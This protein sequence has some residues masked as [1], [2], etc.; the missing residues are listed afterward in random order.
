MKFSRREFGRE[1]LGLVDGDDDRLAPDAQS[2]GNVVIRRGQSFAA[3]DHE[4]HRVGLVHGCQRLAGG[5]RGQFALVVG[6]SAGVD[7]DH[8]APTGVGEAIA[9]IPG[10]ARVVR[11]QRVPGTGELV[12]QRG[13]ANV[14]P[15]HQGDYG[16]HDPAWCSINLVTPHQWPQASLW[17]GAS[18]RPGHPTGV[19][20]GY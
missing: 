17:P 11:N 16:K 10:Q 14:W 6:Q 9:A 8:R 7:H 4:N 12:E 3:I 18:R 5:Q 15:A 13:L 19:R 2:P 1:A 20:Q